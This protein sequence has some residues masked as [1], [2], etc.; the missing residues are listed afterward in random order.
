MSKSFNKE[1][2]CSIDFREY[3]E[4]RQKAEEKYPTNI[5]K[6]I[7]YAEEIMPGQLYMFYLTDIFQRATIACAYPSETIN[8]KEKVELSTGAIETLLRAMYFMIEHMHDGLPEHN[9]NYIKSKSS[10]FFRQLFEQVE[11]YI[12]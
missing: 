11:H 6:Q 3:N 10:T 12:K 8:G 1:E 5:V 4:L 2:Y 9:Y 7:Q